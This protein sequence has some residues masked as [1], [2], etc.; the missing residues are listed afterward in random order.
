M[1]HVYIQY[2]NQTARN[3]MFAI[4]IPPTQK[5]NI[6]FIYVHSLYLPNCR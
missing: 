1:D 2:I 6:Y 4:R 3:N 5:N